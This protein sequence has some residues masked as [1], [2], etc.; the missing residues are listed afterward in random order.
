MKARQDLVSP[1]LRAAEREIDA[2][3]KANPLFRLPFAQAAIQV[4]GVYEDS[5][6]FKFLKGD[7]AAPAEETAFYDDLINT[8]QYP[9]KW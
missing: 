9:L 8:V 4:M 5:A 6:V 2:F 1:K 3:H 7:F